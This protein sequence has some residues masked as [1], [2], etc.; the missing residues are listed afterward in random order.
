MAKDRPQ[1]GAKR[2]QNQKSRR[3]RR[4]PISFDLLPSLIGYNIRRAQVAV[5]HDFAASL[6]SC[7]L[8]PG[9]F[10]VLVLINAN[11]GLNQT[12]LGEA[13]GIE[14]STVVAVI[15]RLEGR[16]LVARTPSPDDRRSHALQLTE[17]GR[18]LLGQAV[19]LV[20]A[21]EARF[22]ER[23]DVDEQEQLLALLQRLAERP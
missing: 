11:P 6:A 3:S 20:R 9:Q 21:H 13:L 15:D 18:T 10:G 14:R 5:F 23:M 12:R 4:P 16:G 7:D 22:A 17:D 19:P 2:A 1:T 8:T